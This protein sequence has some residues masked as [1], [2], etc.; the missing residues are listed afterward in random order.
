MKDNTKWKESEKNN[1]AGKGKETPFRKKYKKEDKKE[2]T[3]RRKNCTELP[4]KKICNEKCLLH[5]ISAN[6]RKREVNG[7]LL[8]YIACF[9]KGLLDTMSK[10]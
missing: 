1:K 4:G 3:Q 10:K 2:D 6:Y 7:D 9:I 5:Q 8:F